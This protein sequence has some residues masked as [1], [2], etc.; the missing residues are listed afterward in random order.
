MIAYQELVQADQS[1]ITV[2]QYT[3]QEP[4]DRITSLHRHKFCEII[5]V[6]QGYCE[7]SYCGEHIV[8]LAGSLM[9]LAPEEVHAIS[10]R[11]GCEIYTCHF[12]PMLRRRRCT[13]CWKSGQP[14]RCPLPAIQRACC[15]GR[16]MNRGLRHHAILSTTIS[17]GCSVRIKHTS[18]PFCRRSR[19]NRQHRMLDTW[20]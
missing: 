15:L 2:L 6:A 19:P 16:I 7:I 3:G 5:F 18:W 8:L 4:A 10:L 13:G 14:Y 12:R 9:L 1:D 17:F 20:T 11:A